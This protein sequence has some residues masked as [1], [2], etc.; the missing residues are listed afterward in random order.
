MAEQLERYRQKEVPTSTKF[1]KMVNAVNEHTDSL[2]AISAYIEEIVN[3]LVPFSKGFKTEGIYNS[4]MNITKGLTILY[5]AIKSNTFKDG[6]ANGAGWQIDKDGHAQVESIEVRSYMRVMELIMNRLSAEE[7]D[8]VFTESGTIDKATL[9]EDGSY[10]LVMRKKTDKDI[11]AFKVGDV[12]KGVVND[13]DAE[14]A[15]GL[16]YYTSWI[17]V[18]GVYTNTNSI[19]VSVYPDDETPAKK[20]FPPCDSMVLHRWGSETDTERQSCWYIS[21]T[22]KRIVMLDGV[23]K[24]IVDESNYASFYGLPYNLSNFKG[25]SLNQSQPYIY[26]RGAILQDVHYVDYQGREIYRMEIDQS[27]GGTLAP[28]ETEEVTI[29]IYSAFGDDVTDRFKKITVR[30]NTSDE[31]SDAVWNAKHKNVG[32]PFPI[33]FNDLGIDGISKVAATFYVTATDEIKD[34]TMSAE[35]DY[36]S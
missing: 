19:R 2:S 34:E 16:T 1:N 14:G 25:I 4:G 35:L 21:S 27:L 33:G 10:S 28:R 12:I 3:G 22:E 32:N 23:T 17:L 13:L 24:P 11:T 5:D 31:A 26:V 18:E 9:N 36:F 15:V 29:T 30:R 7:S 20:N 6:V 8:F